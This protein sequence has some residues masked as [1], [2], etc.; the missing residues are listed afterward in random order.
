MP[1]IT[2][3]IS[4]RAAHECETLVRAMVGSMKHESF[5]VSGRY[6]SE[7]MGVYCG[8]VAHDKSFAASQ[9][10]LNEQKDVALIFSGECFMDNEIGTCL[11]QKGHR[12]EKDKGDWL[13]HLYEEE[14]NQFFE[15]LNGL[16]SGLVIDK[17]QRKAFLFNDRYGIERIYY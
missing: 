4:R 12:L 5:Y 10:F 17:R 3:V 6:R 9:V 16:F 13:V 15:K 14:G 8:W 2:G 7:E 1:G 11:K